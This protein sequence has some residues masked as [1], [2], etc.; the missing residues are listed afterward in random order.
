MIEIIDRE[1]QRRRGQDPGHQADRMLTLTL[2]QLREAGMWRVG[3]CNRFSIGWNRHLHA[4][5]LE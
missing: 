3:A 4:V 2:R 1:D 5:V